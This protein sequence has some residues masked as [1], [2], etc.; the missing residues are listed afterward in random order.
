MNWRAREQL[1][2][3]NTQI[4]QR[5]LQRLFLEVYRRE[6]LDLFREGKVTLPNATHVNYLV[7]EILI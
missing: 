1:V 6:S 5:Q 2:Q 7:E 4:D 3:A